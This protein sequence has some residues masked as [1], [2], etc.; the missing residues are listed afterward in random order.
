L[1]I[2]RALRATGA[3]DVLVHC[4]GMVDVDACERHPLKAFASNAELVQRL[5]RRIPS[6][7][8]IVYISTDSL[9]SNGR[10]F[11]NESAHPQ[12]HTVYAESKWRGEQVVRLSTANHLII[13]TNFYGW[14]SGRKLTAAEWMYRA[15]STNEPVTL[16]DDLYFTPMYVVDLA[17]L[18]EVLIQSRHRGIF[19]LG[20]QDRV[21][22]YRFGELMANA[23]GLPFTHVRKG[24]LSTAPLIAKRPHEMSL[25]SARFEQATGLT[26][27]DCLTG[28][29]HFLE[30][31]GVP[32]SLRRHKS[33][34]TVQVPPN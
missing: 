26:V 6:H 11:A 23:A 34:A 28:L 21:S 19:H 4:A 25:S 20:G 31:R 5:A 16:F 7:C 9:F 17:K 27:P 12:P 33:L 13:R 14:S 15:L 2:E 10:P 18:L 32:L 8:L 22:K 24:S 29:H 3:L 1:S 30:D